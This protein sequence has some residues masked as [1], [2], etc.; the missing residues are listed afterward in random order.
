MMK[1]NV[2]NI[3]F[4]YRPD[5]FPETFSNPKMQERHEQEVEKKLSALVTALSRQSDP[6]KA[7]AILH[8]KDQL[9][10]LL[11]NSPSF[12]QA[13]QYE[14]ALLLLYFRE[15][16]PFVSDGKSEQWNELFRICDVEALLALGDEVSFTTATIYRGSVSGFKRCLCWTPEKKNVNNRQKRWSDTSLRG[17]ELFEVDVS[18]ADVLYYL[19]HPREEKIILDPDFIAK[20]T[21]R[22]YQG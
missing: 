12:Q 5:V 21:I 4:L 2:K 3:A 19:K 11:N 17:G 10:F 7:M 15:N 16:G 20:A 22:E 6:L 14:K 13:K 1:W 18:K 9:Q 8:V